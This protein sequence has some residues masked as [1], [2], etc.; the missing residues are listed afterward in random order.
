MRTLKLVLAY[1]GTEFAGWQRQPGRRTVQGVLA[2]ALRRLTGEEIEPTGSGRTDAGVHA[3]GQVASFQTRSELAA[4][5]IERALNALLPGDL[6]V[7]SACDAPPAFHAVRDARRKRYRYLIDD[8]SPH[9]PFLRRYVWQVHQPLDAW[10]MHGAGQVLVGRHD[11][12]SFQTAGSPRQSTVRTIFWL[13]VRRSAAGPPLGQGRAVAGGTGSKGG[14]SGAAFVSAEQGRG[15]EGG[16]GCGSPHAEQQVPPH[17]HALASRAGEG[18]EN[19]AVPAAQHTAHPER[20]A[21]LRENHSEEEG[22]GRGEL[23]VPQAEQSQL[24][25]A[26]SAARADGAEPAVHAQQTKP[27]AKPCAAHRGAGQG[28]GKGKPPAFAL[29]GSARSDDG[30]ALAGPAAVLGCNNLILIEIEADGFL[31]NMARAIVGTLVEVGRGRRPEG[32]VAEVLSARDRSRA[33]RTAPAHGLYL[34]DVQ[35]D[36]PQS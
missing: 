25:A 1:D 30:L 7:L 9:A 20:P 21:T 15:G 6:R 19:A 22:G 32:W 31:Y 3:L 11:F 12:A 2:E 26:A 35:Y 18:G 8:R 16:A 24:L 14:E 27:A 13:S 28:G 36:A 33:G 29:P 23:C 17:Q 10:A 34:V 4:A 5:T